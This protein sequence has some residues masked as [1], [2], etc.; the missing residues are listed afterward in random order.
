LAVREIL[1]LEHISGGPPC[2][3][4]ERLDYSSSFYLVYVLSYFADEIG[5]VPFFSSNKEMHG[6]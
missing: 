4:M 2:P 1:T 3:G 5:V 6:G